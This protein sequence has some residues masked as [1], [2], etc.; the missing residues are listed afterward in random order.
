[1]KRIIAILSAFSLLL[2]LSFPRT[3]IA[4]SGYD[5]EAGHVD[6]GDGT[7]T[8]S[9]DVPSEDGF[10]D[11]EIERSR[12]SR[13]NTAQDIYFGYFTT[14][15]MTNHRRRG[16]AEWDISSI[17]DN[18]EIES[19]SVLYE[20]VVNGDD[21]S[22]ITLL[23]QNRP[24]SLND[25]RLFSEISGMTGTANNVVLWNY[26]VG[27]SNV[28]LGDNGITSMENSLEGDFFALGFQ[29]SEETIQEYDM[30]SASEKEDAAPKPTLEVVYRA[31]AFDDSD[32]DEEDSSED[33][34]DTNSSDQDGNLLGVDNENSDSDRILAAT[35]ELP[36][37][38]NHLISNFFKVG[39]GLSVL[40]L[41]FWKFRKA[42]EAGKVPWKFVSLK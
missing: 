15:I 10:I 6:N 39:F 24:S 14:M 23:G 2:L 22:Y 18:V 34:E 11:Y 7:C 4:A 3:I 35:D 20:G 1:M 13:F 32:E 21:S 29:N 9:F 33:V 27:S 40:M 26:Q 36:E 41:G 5:C 19:V 37:T 25:E 38:G 17:P 28:D 31:E 30:I 42:V 12:Y 8:A 16:Y